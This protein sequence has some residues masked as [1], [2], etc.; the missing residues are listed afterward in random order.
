MKKEGGRQPSVSQEERERQVEQK[1][2]EEQTKTNREGTLREG[3]ASKIMRSKG[4]FSLLP[5]QNRKQDTTAAAR[6]NLNHLRLQR[7]TSREN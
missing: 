5:K 7:K 4:R 3:I 6:L 2:Q 1:E